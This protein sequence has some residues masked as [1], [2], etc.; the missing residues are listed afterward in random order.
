M[1]VATFFAGAGGLDYGF[2][3]NGFEVIFAND[4]NK[5]A[6]DTYRLNYGPKIKCGSFYDLTRDMFS[7]GDIFIGGPPC[8]GFS[9][10][11]RMDLHDIRN[12]LIVDYFSL[13]KEESPKIFVCENV[14]ALGVLDKW[15]EIREVLFNIL[16]DDYHLFFEVINVSNYGICQKR[17]RTFIIGFR[18]N[19]YD[20]SVI[21]RFQEVLYSHKVQA[22]VLR[23]F[24][25]GIGPVSE[26]NPQDCVATITPCKN[27]V[28][29]KSPYAGMLF[30]GQG[31]VI[32]PDDVAPTIIASLGGSHTPIIDE[33][34][35]Y[36]DGYSFI[37]AYHHNLMNNGPVIKKQDI[38]NTLRRLTLREARAIQSFPEDYRFFGAKSAIYKQI[39]NAVPC[40]F[41]DIIGRSLKEIC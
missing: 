4:M 14:K 18:K 34:E 39:G 41:S 17:E 24:L 19:G 9:V 21:S 32:N 30:N 20:D 1:K 40:A 38:P 8:Q 26:D 13:I 7:D 2:H 10:S 11:G 3:K 12:R 33:R 6:C 23:E 27:P 29:R 25:R 35:M 15:A 31:R 28:L 5:T 36:G 16:K 22:P 37:K